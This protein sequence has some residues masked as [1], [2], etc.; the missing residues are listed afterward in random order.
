MRTDDYVFCQL[1]PYI[2]NKRRLLPLIEQ[3]LMHT[4]LRGGVFVDLFSGSTVVSRLA[5]RLG[6][7]VIANDWEPYAHEIARG[8]VEL[9]RPPDFAALG[10]AEAAFARLNELPPVDGYVAS[11]LCPRDDTA[12]DPTTERMFFTRSNG[13]RI[14]A[15]REQLV[16][17]EANGTI[18]PLERS[19]V[20]AALLY[21]A[22][23]VS[24]T[25]GV[26]KAYH[27]GWGGRTGTALHRILSQLHLHPPV[28]W[29][30]GC[31]NMALR[32]DAQC[33]GGSLPELLGQRSDIVYLDS[34]YNQHPY[35][36]NY[37]L[38]NTIALWD[39]PPISRNVP[40]TG[41][42]GEKAAIRRD[43]RTL[44]RSP[45]NFADEAGDALRRLLGTVDARWIMMSYSSE[46]NVPAATVFRELAGH[47]RLIV[48]A[49]PYRRYRVSTPRASPRAHTTEFLAV[50]ETDANSGLSSTQQIEHDAAHPT[51]G[52]SRSARDCG[53][54]AGLIV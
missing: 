52:A 39:K 30:N 12:P 14:D 29:D 15:I 23:Y 17:W 45:Y 54:A 51:D 1:I 47:G 24:N 40:A 8:T 13:G 10:G 6:F 18:S 41:L 25:S 26:F 22:C 46:G 5:K 19:Y 32:G 28:L 44:R 50:V 3:G 34:P 33:L 35:G 36:S 37:H 49:Q 20:L 43:W 31:H 2:G 11:H 16:E 53:I 7:R 9:N 27:H 42:R 48:F 21:A 38:L 4:G